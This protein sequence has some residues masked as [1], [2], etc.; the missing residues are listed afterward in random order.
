VKAVILAGGL[1]TRMREETEFRPKPMVEV[2]GKPVIWHI[3]KILGSQGISEFVICTGYKGDLI[4]D[5]F[6]NYATRNQDFTVN[7]GNSADVVLHGGHKEENWRVTVTDTGSETMTGGR[8]FLSQR[9]FQNERFLITYGDG[10]ADVNLSNLIN[11][12][13]QNGSVV[14]LTA[15]K[16]RNRFGVLQL[17]ENDI[18][19]QFAEKPEGR[20]WVN[21]GYMI[22]EPEF[23][24]YLKPN[25]VLEEEPLQTLAREEKLSAFRHHGFWQP[26]DTIRE[27]KVLNDLWNSG[28][29]PW[30]SLI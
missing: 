8:I 27:A 6:L 3:M 17:G 15:A 29:A 23:L 21:I 7:L 26:M 12:H 5:Y 4:K 1:G 14:T 25:S 9:H 18:V 20:E 13:E 10:L 28:E 11:F 16:P 30:K 2:G 22:A 24:K 19:Q